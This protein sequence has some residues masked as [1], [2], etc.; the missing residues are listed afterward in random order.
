MFYLSRYFG[1]PEVGSYWEQVVGLNNCQQ[2]RISGL[3]LQRLFGTVIG[4]R[5]AIL[6]FAFKANTNDTRE[7]PAI[8]ISL[9][10]LEEGAQLAIH[11]PKVSSDQIALDLGTLPSN[12]DSELKGEGC[13]Y[14]ANTIAE[15]VDGADAVLILTEWD[16]YRKLDWSML[17]G[18]MRAPAWI[19]DTRS[20]VDPDQIAEA[21][22]FLWRLGVG[23]D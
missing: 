22:L 1:L 12:P 4:K 9:D 14:F 23:V 13:W 17:A 21:G 16:Q 15:A 7:S 10:L 19:F 5:L 2:N 11:D 8:R 3:L 20:V 6:G 18:L